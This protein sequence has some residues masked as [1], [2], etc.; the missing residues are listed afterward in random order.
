[1]MLE[2]VFWFLLFAGVMIVSRM[3]CEWR[4]I[5]RRLSRLC[6]MPHERYLQGLGPGSDPNRVPVSRRVARKLEHSKHAGNSQ[7]AFAHRTDRLHVTCH[8]SLQ[9]VPL[10]SNG[11]TAAVAQLSHFEGFSAPAEKTKL[12]SAFS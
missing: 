2:G 5:N 12:R 11:A 1:M 6:D 8:G 10:A 9:V 4:G 7:R 3:I